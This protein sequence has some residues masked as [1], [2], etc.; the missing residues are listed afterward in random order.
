MENKKDLPAGEKLLEA[1][2]L[3]CRIR[4]FEERA[5][6]LY[7][8]GLLCGSFLGALHTYIGEEAI[9][10]GVCLNLAKDDYIFSTHRGHGHFIARGGR[11]DKTLAE[12]QGKETGCCK[13]RGGSMH[14]FDPSIG[15]LGANGIVGGGI[16]LAIGSGYSALYR[17]TDQVT[18]CFFGD[19]GASQGTFHESLNMAGLWKLP[20]VFVCENNCYAVTTSVGD[21]ICVANVAQRASGYNMP[22]EVVDGNDF[23]AVYR[24]AR[25]AIEHTRKGKG[26]YLLECKTYRIDPHCMVL[27]EMRTE[28]ELSEWKTQR[29]PIIRLEKYLKKEKLA[30]DPEL[31]TIRKEILFEINEAERFALASK[32]PDPQEF[33]REMG[34]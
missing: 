12:L 4:F 33:K 14:L 25:Q 24:A 34:T 32:F 31:E 28:C 22:G 13:G 1:F 7:K 17:G 2:R 19:G 30:G 16:P 26:P 15:F 21:T 9:A 6:T 27:P 18:V 11:T 23:L 5:K 10:V 20:V 29:D 8:K 3:M